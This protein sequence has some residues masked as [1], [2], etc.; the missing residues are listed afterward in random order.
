M[1]ATCAL[2]TACSD[3]ASSSQGRHATRSQV[4]VSVEAEERLRALLDRFET[5]DHEGQ[6][7]V[8]TTVRRELDT[9]QPCLIDILW[10]ANDVHLIAAIDVAGWVR[11]ADAG[12]LIR[13][14]SKD[15]REVVRAAAIQAGGRLGMWQRQDLA[16]F[17]QE[18]A[19]PIL[20]AALHAA[21][22]AI[23]VPLD[24][25]LPLLDHEQRDLQRLALRAIPHRFDDDHWEVVEAQASLLDTHAQIALSRV[26]AGVEADD[27]AQHALI[28][29][30]ASPELA[31]NARVATLQALAIRDEPIEEPKPI[32]RLAVDQS[33]TR[34]ERIAAWLVI[35]RCCKVRSDALAS[36]IDGLHPI[37][38][39][40]AARCLIAKNSLS[41]IRRLVHI[42]DTYAGHQDTEKVEASTMA[43]RLLLQ[44]AGRDYGLETGGWQ[45]WVDSMV[46]CPDRKLDL[47]RVF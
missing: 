30:L 45:A 27:R 20:R 37:E 16:E 6:G 38:Q 9:L 33:K 12:P 35:E 26:L 36:F 22:H 10:R 40:S 2:F 39:V 21:Q 15:L 19:E 18:A 25:L 31:W 34:A 17:L 23:S 46:A 28:G 1:S 3:D 44:L 5:S 8:I 32:C 29:M 14:L 11:L 7:R 42:E 13:L 4:A 43:N 47:P 24:R 41:G